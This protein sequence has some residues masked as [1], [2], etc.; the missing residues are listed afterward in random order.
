MPSPE[1]RQFNAE[2][3]CLLKANNPRTRSFLSFIK[4]TLRQFHLEDI[5]TEFD[6]FNESY[7]RGVDFILKGSS[8]KSPKAWMRKTAYNVIRERSRDNHRCQPVESE[9]M[10]AL[11]VSEEIIELD[12]EVV[13]Q[14]YLELESSDRQILEL[15]I[16]E[17]L[18]WRD[19]GERF[20]EM[21]E[22]PQNE[23][24]LRKRGQRAMQRLR[25]IY[26]RSRPQES[27]VP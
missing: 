27:L 23:P 9:Y 16:V 5:H 25:E 4:R 13:R 12:L 22:S 21:G 6:I 15:R 11:L 7:L 3:Y 20:V 17:N 8:I 2:I 26:H 10:E 14:A 18:S 19:I 24:A 1:L